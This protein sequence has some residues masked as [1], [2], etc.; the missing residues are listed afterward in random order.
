[1][2]GALLAL[3]LL[4]CACGGAYPGG[5]YAAP[6]YRRISASEARAIMESGEDFILLDAR[7]EPE[8]AARRIEG[9]ALMPYSEI[10]ARAA[11]ELPDKG[12]VILVYCQAGRRSELAARALVAM[13]YTQVFDFG[14]IADW[15]YGTVSP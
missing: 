5:G 3:A 12:A 2:R 9:A 14:G 7:T 11:L 10:A 15:P 1:M 6:A 4:L 13:G 8:F